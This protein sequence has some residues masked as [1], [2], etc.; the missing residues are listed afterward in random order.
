MNELKITEGGDSGKFLY[1]HWTSILSTELCEIIINE[2]R[3]LTPSLGKVYLGGSISSDI[4]TKQRESNLSFFPATHWVSGIC[5][6]YGYLANEYAWNYDL[7][8]PEPIQFAQYAINNHYVWHNDLLGTLHKKETW[9]WI[10]SA[11]YNPEWFDNT[12][13]KISL[14]INLSDPS[15]YDGGDIEFSSPAGEVS[16]PK[17]GRKQGSVIAF[18][19]FVKHRVTPVT[20]GTRYSLVV[21]ITGPPFK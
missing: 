16:K 5:K 1:H 17:T 18:P 15:T 12:Q 21:W 10:E 2:G 7:R 11:G 4:D 9:K 13:R 19:S 6:Y 14:T 3:S 8:W 20:K